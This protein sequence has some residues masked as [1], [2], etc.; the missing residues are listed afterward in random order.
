M[1]QQAGSNTLYLDGQGNNMTHRVGNAFFS[2]AGFCRFAVVAALLALGGCGG[3]NTIENAVP[4]SQGAR[5]TGSFPNLNIKPE[6]AAQQFT[7]A[8]RN[9]K[10]SQLKA[11][12]AQAVASPGATT[13]A[14]DARTLSKLATSHANDTLK[15]IQAKCDPALD[16]TCK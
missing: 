1:G 4:V 2:G 12:Q 16:P 3:G 15:Q 10:L 14:A 6:V 13:E 7:D 9:D 5:D 11:E 8:E